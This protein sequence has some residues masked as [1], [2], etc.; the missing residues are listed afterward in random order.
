VLS[1]DIFKEVDANDSRS[2]KLSLGPR[3][4][5]R[6]AAIDPFATELTR[7]ITELAARY[8]DDSAAGGRAHRLVVG[9]Y[10]VPEDGNPKRG[11]SDADQEG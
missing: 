3:R 2:K 6:V 11:G 10:P 8:L 5:E 7:A 1:G 9:A 4:Q